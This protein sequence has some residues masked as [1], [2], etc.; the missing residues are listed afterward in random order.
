MQTGLTRSIIRKSEKNVCRF[1]CPRDSN[2]YPFAVLSSA[3]APQEKK[4]KLAAEVPEDER[5]RIMTEKKYAN[6][7]RRCGLL[8][9]IKSH[10]SPFPGADGQGLKGARA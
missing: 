5:D 6:M 10:P 1:E 4:E 3:P 8:M 7:A 2:K 9:P